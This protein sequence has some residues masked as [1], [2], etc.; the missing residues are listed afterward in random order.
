[1]RLKRKRSKPSIDAEAIDGAVL[2][3]CFT[4]AVN[5]V[6]NT[7]NSDPHNMPLFMVDVYPK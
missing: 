1:L 5:G 4:D 7:F 6:R 2:F 3:Q